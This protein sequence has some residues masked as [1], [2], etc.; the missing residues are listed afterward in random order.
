MSRVD[1][2]IQKVGLQ[3]KSASAPQD[4]TKQQTAPEEPVSFRN[5]PPLSLKQARFPRFSAAPTLGRQVAGLA[6]DISSYPGRKIISEVEK[7]TLN[8]ENLLPREIEP[9]RA[10]QEQARRELMAKT[11]GD[12]FWEN[13]A[14]SPKT[15][16]TL[17]T[18]PLAGGAAFQGIKGGL[19]L[20]ALEGGISAGVGETARFSE[21]GKIDPAEAGK[22]IASNVVLST[23]FP[24]FGAGARKL[25]TKIFKTGARPLILETAFK[26]GADVENLF[27][28]KVAGG[29]EKSLERVSARIEELSE[30]LMMQVK[31]KKGTI[32]LSEIRLRAEKELLSKL[33]KGT[34][35]E[36]GEEIIKEIDKWQDRIELISPGGVADWEKVLNFKRSVG[37][38]GKFVR[39]G[40]SKQQSKEIVANELFD[41]FRQVLS[42]GIPETSMINNQLSELIPLKTPLRKAA[43]QSE[44]KLVDMRDIVLLLGGT[45]IG[46]QF[47][48]SGAA[49]GAFP[50]LALLGGKALKSPAFGA[51]LR[52]LTENKAF[53]TISKMGQFPLRRSVSEQFSPTGEIDPRRNAIERSINGGR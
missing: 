39:G 6:A 30:T 21:T 36:V 3:M 8:E 49:A 34:N 46:S 50:A 12:N 11:K 29:V 22:E 37:K 24:V 15:I 9:R 1:E 20:G 48:A 53:R 18:L 40:D 51:G 2:L 19:K 41:Q 45:G 31:R 14:R 16:P 17:A 23:L 47:G 28:H 32:S 7:P 43:L 10:Q 13:V 5:P 25:G 42:D 27:K 44:G 4:V 52:N 33:D 35:A 26:K 38:A